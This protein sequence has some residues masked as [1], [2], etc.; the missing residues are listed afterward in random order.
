[1]FLVHV[2]A[3]ILRE[4]R[5]GDRE[6]GQERETYKTPPSYLFAVFLTLGSR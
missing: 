5:D 3:Y 2:H 6:G 4:E 1:M